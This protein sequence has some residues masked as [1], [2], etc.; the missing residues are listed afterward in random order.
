MK[1]VGLYLSGKP[2]NG[3][4]YQYWLAM[5]KAIA[6]LDKTKYKVVLF[7]KYDQWRSIAGKYELK[8]VKLEEKRG[9]LYSL[10]ERMLWRYKNSFWRDFFSWLSMDLSKIKKEN[11]DVFMS[12]SV[13]GVGDILGIPTIIPIFDL[14]HRYEK[15]IIEL[16]EEYDGREA[17]YVHQ[18]KYAQIILV[19]SNV[20]KEH[21][22][23]C[24]GDGTRSLADKVEV[25]PFIPPEYIYTTKSIDKINYTLFDKYLFYPAQFWTHKNHIRL[26]EAID[27]LNKEGLNINLVLVGSEQN[28]KKN[29]EE[30]ICKRNLEKNVVILGYVSNEEMVY[31]Y[32]HARALVMP[33]LF[34]PTNIPQLEAFELGCPVVTS[35][36]YGI[37]E[38]VGDAA[39]LFNPRSIDEIQEAVRKV[40]IDDELCNTLI[41]RGRQKA[42]LWNQKQFSIRLGEIL[43]RYFDRENKCV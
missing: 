25:L 33:T 18:C 39:L 28:N 8:M 16:K 29:V 41:K 15:E 12:N 31:L 22:I 38:Q 2:N 42:N 19:D 4:S 3:G 11:L 34:G 10:V 13:N 27:N 43:E 32:K 1:T 30:E 37:P 26:L 24:Y 7:Y 5:L 36:I 20:G 14:M 23:Q 17:F 6:E 21:V 9:V 40:W 35:G